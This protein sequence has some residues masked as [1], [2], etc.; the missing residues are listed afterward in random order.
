MNLRPTKKTTLTD[1]VA[2]KQQKVTDYVQAKKDV[3]TKS[4]EITISK[5][6]IIRL[7]YGS[8]V[9]LVVNSDNKRIKLIKI[10]N[11]KNI[12]RQVMSRADII[13]R[14][15]NGAKFVGQNLTFL[16]ELDK[17]TALISSNSDDDDPFFQSMED[18]D[19]SPYTEVDLPF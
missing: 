2:M 4:D 10:D 19:E 18:D 3:L 16:N 13:R 6:D 8:A 15:S 17:I 1:A 12:S 7:N 5:G 9:V 14:L 11:D